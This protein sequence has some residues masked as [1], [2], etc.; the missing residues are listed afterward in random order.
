[1]PY[2]VLNK[3]DRPK[4]GQ[5]TN[6]YTGS[7]G[8]AISSKSGNVEEAVR[9]LDYGYSPEGHLFFNFG[10]ENISYTMV[11]GYPTYTDLI[12][13]NPDRLAPSQALAM[14]NRASYFG[15]FVQDVRY[16]EQYYV[17]PEQKEATRIWSDTDAD[18]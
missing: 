2:P 6:L 1:A 15:P 17:L 9:M 3:G 13:R 12:L 5:R 7:G 11:D 10:L 8:V 4:F 18:S 16:L 14:Y